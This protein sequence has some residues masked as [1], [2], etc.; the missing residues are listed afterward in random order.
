MKICKTGS[1]F[2][3]YHLVNILIA[4]LATINLLGFGV[5][6]NSS[7]I[8]S[9]LFINTKFFFAIGYAAA[10]AMHSRGLFLH[11]RRHS[12]RR[13]EHSLFFESA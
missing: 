1:A 11:R 3:F 6:N 5:S 4:K 8:L 13:K 9:Q 10:P 7:Q 2:S 12:I